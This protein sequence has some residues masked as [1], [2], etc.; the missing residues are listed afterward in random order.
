MNTLDREATAQ[1]CGARDLIRECQELLHGERTQL[2]R[3]E[4]YVRE[5]LAYW[6]SRA[7]EE[8]LAA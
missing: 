6:R 4:D 7:E 2:T 3:R 5:R 8:E 1:L